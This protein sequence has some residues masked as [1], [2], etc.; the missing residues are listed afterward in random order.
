ML[1]GFVG[2]AATIVSGLLARDSVSIPTTVEPLIESHEQV[3]FLVAAL[4]AVLLFWRI[5]AKTHL[6]E[7]FLWGYI[8]LTLLGVVLMWIGAWYGG[9]MVYHFG[10]GVTTR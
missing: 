5:G 6:P 7:R 9:E 2:L 10:L 4:Y 8:A 1:F 3:A